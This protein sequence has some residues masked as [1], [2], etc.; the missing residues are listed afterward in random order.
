VQH[1]RIVRWR[2]RPVSGYAKWADKI[3]AS[4]VRNVLDGDE[5][6]AAATFEEDPNCIFTIKHRSGLAPI[7]QL[8]RKPM[9]DLKQADGIGGGQIQAVKRCRDGFR[10]LT[11]KI[12][13]RLN[14]ASFPSTSQRSRNAVKRG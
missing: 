5:S 3:P 10:A 4:Y 9:F 14:P 8:A 13:N 7:V 12:L 2:D 11:R 6:K 1:V